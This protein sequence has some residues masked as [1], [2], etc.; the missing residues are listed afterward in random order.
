MQHYD[1]ATQGAGLKEDI[2]NAPTD[3]EEGAI[4]TTVYP[5]NASDIYATMCRLS[6]GNHY[7]NLRDYAAVDVLNGDFYH[8]IHE[9]F[10]N[11]KYKCK[12]VGKGKSAAAACMILGFDCIDNEVDSDRYLGVCNNY[13]EVSIFQVLIT[14]TYLTN[15]I[16]D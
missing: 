6:S 14:L 1:S 11:N 2:C 3:D 8:L 5:D 7:G 4:F 15:C 16:N 10:S 13:R 12:G 9:S